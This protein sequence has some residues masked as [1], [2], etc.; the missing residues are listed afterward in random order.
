MF[1]EQ[2]LPQPPAGF[3][4]G[5]LPG[6]VTPVAAADGRPRHPIDAERLWSHCAGNLAT[7]QS[8]LGQ[9]E[10]YGPPQMERMLQGW[11]HD[12][13]NVVAQA[14][15][16]LQGAATTLAAEQ[17]RRLASAT[18]LAAR[19]GDLE[20]LERAI[21]EL[22]REMQ[23]CVDYIPTARAESQRLEDSLRMA[24]GWNRRWR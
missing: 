15:Q 19:G 10:T 11:R 17:L 16:T 6:P 13:L 4:P 7:I 12:N 23:R 5:I 24:P 21:G 2:H 9:L 18:E 20:R 1:P 14:A 22:Q 3:L 8:L